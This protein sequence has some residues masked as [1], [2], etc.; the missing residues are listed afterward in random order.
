MVLVVFAGGDAGF[1]EECG[2]VLEGFGE[3]FGVEGVVVLAD[4]GLGVDE[5][6]AGAVEDGA[7]LLSG[8][9]WV[10]GDGEEEVFFDEVAGLGFFAGEEGPQGEVGLD[11]VG[12]LGEDLWGVVFGVDG[13]GDELGVW[14]GGAEGDL[15][16]LD[17]LDEGWA[18][19]WAACEGEGDEGDFVVEDGVGNGLL[20]LVDELEW[21][22][23][24]DD[25]EGGA[26][27]G[28]GLL[29]GFEDVGGE[30]G[31]DGEGEEEPEGVGGEVG[32]HG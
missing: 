5:G 12:V 30:G 14:V 13:D 24:A 11:G 19:A 32:F 8:F 10:I 17:S 25:G 26:G 6:D 7:V 31:D 22:D 16:L 18:W 27:W 23:D 9:G 15:E 4:A 2:D 1:A 3:E 21:G 28:W 20:V 29:I